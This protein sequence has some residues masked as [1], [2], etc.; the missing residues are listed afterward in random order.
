[1][2]EC[3]P[4]DGVG[5]EGQLDIV[6]VLQCF[7]HGVRQWA[8]LGN[9]LTLVLDFARKLASILEIQAASAFDAAVQA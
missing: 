4:L 7:D 9:A 1:M 5:G 2:R 3:I 6:V 8:Q